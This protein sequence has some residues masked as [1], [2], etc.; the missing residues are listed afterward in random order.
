MLPATRTA[1]P[2]LVRRAVATYT[3]R[4]TCLCATD[5]IQPEVAHFD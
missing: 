1:I 5:R 4:Q 2:D 3:V